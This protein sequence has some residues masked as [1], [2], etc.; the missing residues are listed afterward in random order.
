MSS[1]STAAWGSVSPLTID[2]LTPAD[3]RRL[4]A[5]RLE[6][7]QDAPE[8]FVT[9]YDIEKERSPEYWIELLTRSRW[10]AAY[11]DAEMVGIA[12]LAAQDAEGPGERF[13]ESVWVEKRQRRQGL[14]RRML[15]E[16]EDRARM[17][18]AVALQ[19][20]VLD[21]NDS[22]ADA[23]LKLGFGWVSS[24]VQKSTKNGLDGELVPERLMRR[25]LL[26]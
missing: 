3:W 1:R 12:C 2:V 21:T 6:A 15:K 25:P 11:Q 9:T 7:L 10:V 5:V 16:L 22:A 24:R 18:G 26:Q 23:Y 4:K 14:V 20:W 8:A 19:L 13:I 17:D